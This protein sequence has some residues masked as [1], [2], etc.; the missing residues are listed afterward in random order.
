MRTTYALSSPC[1]YKNHL[2]VRPQFFFVEA[3]DLLL[4]LD[5]DRK[6]IRTES[7]DLCDALLD[8]FGGLPSA[9]KTDLDNYGVVNVSPPVVPN[10]YLPT[11]RVFSYNITGL[12]TS[13]T[14]LIDRSQGTTQSRGRKPSH[15]R[16]DHGN[17]ATYCPE[18]EYRYS[19]KCILNNTWHSDPKAPSRSNQLWSPLGYAQVCSR[20]LVSERVY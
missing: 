9:G 13:G 14:P 2:I 16:G 18:E 10:P 7:E 3:E 8:D 6:K 20:A 5:Q 12:Q 17:K 1:A 19:W 15:H 11:F 4:E